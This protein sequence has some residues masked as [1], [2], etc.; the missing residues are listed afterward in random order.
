VAELEQLPADP[1]PATEAMD[2]IRSMMTQITVTP[3]T[4]AAGVDLEPS[5]DL[6]RILHLCSAGS[7]EQSAQAVADSDHVARIQQPMERFLRQYPGLS[8]RVAL[9]PS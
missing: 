3:R 9:K 4:D 6:A 7:Q 2:L 8:G 5:G 1:E